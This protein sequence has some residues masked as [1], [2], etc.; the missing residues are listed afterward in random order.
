M[1]ANSSTITKAIRIGVEVIA[2]Y[3]VGMPT[4]AQVI[5]GPTTACKLQT[6]PSLGLVQRDFVS[7]SMYLYRPYTSPL[8]DLYTPVKVIEVRY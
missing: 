7:N 4:M 1:I 3:Y 6:G 2:S 8:R 5:E